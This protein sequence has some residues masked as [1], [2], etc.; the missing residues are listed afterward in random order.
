MPTEMTDSQTSFQRWLQDPENAIDADLLIANFVA[1]DGVE[2]VFDLL[3]AP[4]SQLQG[5]AHRWLARLRERFDRFVRDG[6]S[7][8]PAPAVKVSFWTGSMER[9]AEELLAS[10][11]PPDLSYSFTSRHRVPSDNPAHSTS[12][13]CTIDGGASGEGTTPIQAA[14][15]AIE[16]WQS[17]GTIAAKPPQISVPSAQATV[18]SQ[19]QKRVS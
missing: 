3:N 18:N 6:E 17:A 7:L 1:E 12:W 4:V 19:E 14:R 11:L 2:M 5:S 9:A 10:K 16:A 15:K 13:V 8:R